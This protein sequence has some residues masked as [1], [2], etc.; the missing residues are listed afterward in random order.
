MCGILQGCTVLEGKR[1]A[2]RDVD[3]WKEAQR[4]QRCGSLEG[5]QYRH[6]ITFPAGNSSTCRDVRSR[7]KDPAQVGCS[8]RTRYSAR[9]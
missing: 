9:E 4:R 8:G 2:D 5:S 6:K 1:S 7:K 3:P